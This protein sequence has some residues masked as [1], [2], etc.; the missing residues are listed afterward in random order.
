MERLSSSIS[1][2]P[3]PHPS[4]YPH[5]DNRK[6]QFW[7]TAS[8]TSVQSIDFATIIE[9]CGEIR[10]F[11][12]AEDSKRFVTVMGHVVYFWRSPI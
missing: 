6:I 7:D 9:N 11:V 5:V 12:W 4:S 8:G 1:P 10:W 3:S 2:F